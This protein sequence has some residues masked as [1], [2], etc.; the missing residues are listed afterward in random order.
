MKSGTKLNKKIYVV[1][2][3]L[4]LMMISCGVRNSPDSASGASDRTVLSNET[5]I[6]SDN[7]SE[8]NVISD[9]HYMEM[10][11][12]IAPYYNQS[13]AI[14]SEWLY[15]TDQWE[16]K[17][18]GG[19]GGTV[20]FGI[21]RKRFSDGFQERNYALSTIQFLQWNK[22]FL[23]ADSA[24]NCYLFWQLSDSNGDVTY[25]L[26]K[27]GT[28]GKMLW[29]TEHSLEDLAGMGERL[30]HGT[31][32]DEGKV[33]LWSYGTGGSV[34]SFSL[35]GELETVCTPKL[36]SLEG[37]VI[38]R[39][40]RVYGYCITGEEPVF[41]E[42]GNEEN[43]YVCPMT[44]LTVYDGYEEGLCL[45]TGEAMFSYLPETGETK[46]LWGWN[47]EAVQINYSQVDR[48]FYDS[49]RYML[50]CFEMPLSG[51]Y[52]RQILTAADIRLQAGGN[53]PEKQTVMLATDYLADDTKRIVQMYNRQSEKY[54]IEIV[55]EENGDIL[56]KKL[57]RGEGADLM[58]VGRI[59][60]GDL[61]RQGAFE[62]LEPYY[63]KS[64][65]IGTEDILESVQEACVIGGKNVT[66]IP[67][68]RIS[69]MR[70][71]GDFV[72][73]ED[74]TVWKFL[75]IGRENRMF[76]SQSPIVALNYCMGLDYGEHFI[77]YE[78]KT[79]SFDGDEFRRILEA[80]AEWEQFSEYSANGN[81]IDGSAAKGDWLFD[82]QYIGSAMDVVQQERGEWYD[83]YVY[84]GENYSD[85]LVG[86]P[87]WE[88][89][90][91]PMW[92]YQIFA[93]NSA[94]KNKEGAWDFLEYLL[95][96]EIQASMRQ[97]S[98]LFPARKDCFETGLRDIY[99]DPFSVEP[100]LPTEEDFQRVC[101]MVDS[102]LLDDFGT[103]SNPVWA[104]V[105][106]EAGMYFAGDAALDATV[107]KIQTRV[108]LFLNEL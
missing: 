78:N 7:G 52:T 40:N 24:G 26:E 81:E 104:I 36:E 5:Q 63:E 61:A 48:M 8:M 65:V 98:G 76:S 4:S 56:Q 3:L 85:T 34:F 53:L 20:Y 44:P 79:C 58:E 21:T 82:L 33:Y 18:N 16:E 50:L 108:Q 69:T 25:A 103:A 70:A 67:S 13:Y 46:R 27:Y 29:H 102:A 107:Q 49:G 97:I 22:P 11:F 59:Y 100:I 87:G 45:S 62:D 14:N 60:T 77:D 42:L 88:G 71:R 54:H 92:A 91:Y 12:E 99:L 37:V 28:D 10:D 35:N 90:E 30:D 68:F 31:V 17:E 19:E 32:T 74:W 106:E 72:T 95:S 51:I 15:V 105:S 1:V 23:L 47:D 101:E 86:Y 6:Y 57:L 93:I 73:A 94:S 2:F 66:V 75:E 55:V 39:E 83:Q 38:G 43:R 80:C 9:F 41:T 64:D 89:G 84:T 96:E